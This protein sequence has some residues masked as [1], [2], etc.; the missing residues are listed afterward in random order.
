MTCYEKI[1][2]KEQDKETFKKLDEH[3]KEKKEHGISRGS[4]GE[5]KKLGYFSQFLLTSSTH[6]FFLFFISPTIPP[7]ERGG[8]K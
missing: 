3:F 1:R 6:I 8:I 5:N 4:K 7:H 2:K